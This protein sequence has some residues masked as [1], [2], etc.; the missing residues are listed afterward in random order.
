MSSGSNGKSPS[1]LS[2]ERDTISNYFVRAFG[3]KKEYFLKMFKNRNLRTGFFKKIL[4]NEIK[5]LKNR[6]TLKRRI[7]F[8]TVPSVTLCEVSIWG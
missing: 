4:V 3:Y 6:G 5:E 8:K 1:R 7:E 2:S